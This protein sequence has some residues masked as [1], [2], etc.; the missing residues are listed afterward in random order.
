MNFLYYISMYLC[1]V[2]FYMCNDHKEKYQSNP[3]RVAKDISLTVDVTDA[4]V[5]CLR[6]HTHT[7][8]CTHLVSSSP[9]PMI[10]V[11]FYT[12]ATKQTWLCSHRTA[13]ALA[14]DKALWR[15]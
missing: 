7:Q 9:T 10:R 11:W 4:S 6:S 8:T 5:R 13:R 2:A 1:F 12:T 14:Q 3:L 15:G